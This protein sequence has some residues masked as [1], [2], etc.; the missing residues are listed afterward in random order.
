MESYKSFY[1]GIQFM[2]PA[3][4]STFIMLFISTLFL[5]STFAEDYM[6]WELPEGAKMRLGKGQ[7]KSYQFS[8]DNTQLAVMSSIGIW[9]YDVQTGKAVKLLTEHSG[10][11]FSPDWQTFAKKGKNNTV[12]LWELHTNTLKKSFEGHTENT[13]PVAFS[14]D[15]KMIASGDDAGVTRLWDIESGKHKSILTPHKSVSKV[16]FSPDGQ[17]IMSRGNNDYQLWDTA[18]GEFKA[19]L[20]DTIRINRVAFN[21]DGTILFGVSGK[22]LRLWDTHTGKI[23]MRLGVDSSYPPPVLSPDGQTIASARWSDS[24]VELWDSQTGKLKRTLIGNPEY[25]KGIAI[26]NG[27]PKLVDYP[28]KPIS[29]I[30]FSPDGQTLAASSRH[31]IVFWDTDTGQQKAILIGDGDF[32]SLLFSSD[33]KTL[34]ARYKSEI[35]LWNIDATNIQKSE[36]RHTISGYSSEVNSIAFSSDGQQLAGGHE[37]SIRLWHLRNYQSQV[38]SYLSQ[39]RSV[40]FSPN[41]KTLAS[42][43]LST[44]SGSKAEIFLW[45]AVTGEY[46]VSLKGHGNVPG[47][48]I[49][50]QSSLAFSPN[51]EVLV[52]GSGDGTLRLWNGKTTA[53]DSFFH[54]LRGGIFGHHKATLKGHTD[55]VLSVAFSS[56]GRTLASS[57]SDETVRLWDSRRRRLKATLEGHVGRVVYL[58][59]SPDGKTLASGGRRGILL[60]DPITAQHKA[61]LILMWNPDTMKYIVNLTED[62]RL[63][64][65]KPKPRPLGQSTHNRVPPD[66]VSHVVGIGSLTFSPDGKTL[67]SA[68]SNA[69]VLLDLSTLEVKKSFS[70]HTDRVNSVAFSPDGRTLA[71]GSADGTVLI[72]ELDP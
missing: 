27:V 53:R 44:N 5:P 55:H 63:S 14:P 72:W 51:G 32:R 22:E 58:A 56:D 13:V 54:R 25:V 46:Q 31:E 49:P 43:R 70:G 69:I 45:D 10:V 62:K 41:G 16:I 7:I 59:F 47:R 28:I 17:T 50:N 4:V 60:W 38:L 71:S 12:E 8:P 65:P 15:G 26:T 61:T 64:L 30:A 57:S 66:P 48:T 29:S 23:K 35:Y 37:R 2:K 67:A 20:E 68:T 42:L 39:V 9:L 1:R 24:T 6:R 33:G 18:T 34:A 11:V 52:S 19:R 36:L 40:A 21:A 3:C